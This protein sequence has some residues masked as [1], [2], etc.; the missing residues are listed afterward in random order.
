MAL[1]EGLRVVC[2]NMSVL[3]GCMAQH[4]AARL[5]SSSAVLSRYRA[6][7]EP[8]KGFEEGVAGEAREPRSDL[9][10]KFWSPDC[11]SS[12]ELRK[13]SLQQTREAFQRQEGDCG[14]SEV[15]VAALTTKIKAMAAH[16]RVHRKDYHSRRGLQ[17]MLNQRRTLLQYLRRK[18]FD[19]YA[20]VLSRLGL[21]D[22]YLKLERAYGQS[23]ATK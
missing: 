1:L 5:L 23:R 22:N 17:A 15:Q 4:H 7:M 14:S 6:P 19:S 9:V 3:P 20:I 13:L 16:M 12:A 11:M 10:E 2:Q 8:P 21:K 18:D